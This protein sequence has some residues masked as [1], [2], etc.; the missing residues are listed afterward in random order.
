MYLCL[1]QCAG[2]SQSKPVVSSNTLLDSPIHKRSQRSDSV[3]QR[4]NSES[5]PASSMSSPRTQCKAQG[6]KQPSARDLRARYWAFL[7][8]NLRRAVDAIYQ[9]CETDESVVECKVRIVV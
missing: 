4:S 9:T 2:K 3:P 1:N 5:R 7:F 6:S 8:D